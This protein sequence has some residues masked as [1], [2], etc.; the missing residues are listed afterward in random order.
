[1]K[2]MLLMLA[3]I[4]GFVSVN[5]LTLHD[6]ARAEGCVVWALNDSESYWDSDMDDTAYTPGNVVLGYYSTGDK[7]R[8]FSCTEAQKFCDN[9]HGWSKCIGKSQK[10][11]YDYT[12][13]NRCVAIAHYQVNKGDF[14]ATHYG[15][16]SSKS[17]AISSA[18]FFC[19]SDGVFCRT[20]F[21]RCE[22][23]DY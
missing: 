8:S 17:S 18:K 19:S 21:S 4:F 3:M 1:M 15:L 7:S 22:S 14:P 10:Y 16:G 12:A 13:G 20:V 5:L 2:K 9:R 6:D 23:R 11:G